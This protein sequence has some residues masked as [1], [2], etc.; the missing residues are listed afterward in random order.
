[1]KKKIFEAALAGIDDKY[2]LEASEVELG[3]LFGKPT[4]ADKPLKYAFIAAAVCVMALAV[5]LSGM[6]LD[7]TPPEITDPPQSTAPGQP[8]V[9]PEG[10]KLSALTFVSNGNG[11]STVEGLVDAESGEKIV[12]R[13]EDVDKAYGY[14]SEKADLP[15]PHNSIIV[16]VS[17][18]KEIVSV[19]P[20][21]NAKSVV[22][23]VIP[24]GV[25]H[26]F[27]MHVELLLCQPGPHRAMQHGAG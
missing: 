15:F 18:S 2:I 21:E 14:E 12:L 9:I 13:D 23:L 22:N 3:R 16:I 6:W 8:P 20:Y 10:Y 7:T 4:R 1:M 17:G 27:I 5:S 11:T 24:D 26:I 19:S 25:E